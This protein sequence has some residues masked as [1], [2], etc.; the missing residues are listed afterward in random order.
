MAA[1]KNPNNI[2]ATA[3][4]RRIGDESAALRLQ[5]AGWFVASPE[6][7]A[8]IEAEEWGPL[9]ISEWYAA[10]TDELGV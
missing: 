3:A 10:K 6:E 5:A 2:N 9:R 4:R 7:I 1:P 8:K